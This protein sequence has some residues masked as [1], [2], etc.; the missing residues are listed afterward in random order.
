MDSNNSNSVESM[1]Q[2]V[3]TVVF[4]IHFYYIRD[5]DLE[6]DLKQEGFLKA[7]E[8]LAEGNYDPTKSLRTFIYTGVRNA[9]TNYM[10]HHNKENHT[11]L[12]TINDQMWQRYELITSDN[13]W[14]GKLFYSNDS[15]REEYSIDIDLITEICNK[16]LMFGDYTNVIINELNKLGV[17]S[18]TAE[19]PKDF[20]VVNYVKDAIIG[21]IIYNTIHRN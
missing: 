5:K 10:Y 21:E 13:Y 14:E 18:N 7:Y 19:V 9:M 12:D 20:K 11:D 17:Y 1:I 4:R 8:L 6:E 16:Y 3:V 2:N 15:I